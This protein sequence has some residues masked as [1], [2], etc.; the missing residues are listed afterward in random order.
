[1]KIKL[2]PLL[3]LL[4]AP[5]IT[6]SQDGLPVYT[7][8]LAD[9][10]YVIHPS[11]AGAA[12]GTR[13]RLGARQQWFDQKNAP[14]LQTLNVASRITER[15]GIG[16]IVFNDQNG[17]HS[18]TGGYLTYAHHIPFSFIDSELNQLS[19]GLS[20]GIIDSRLD[21]TQFNLENYDPIIY[22]NILSATYF[23][24]DAGVSYHFLDFAAHFTVKNLLYQ[25][26]LN[27]TE[28]IESINQRKYLLGASYA[29]GTMNKDWGFE[30]SFMFM[31]TE[32]TQETSVDLNFRAIKRFDGGRGWAGLSYRRALDTPDFEEGLGSK[33]D[34]M[35]HITPVIGI[36]FHNFVFAY[37]YSYQMGNVTFDNGGFHHLTLGYNFG[38]RQDKYDCNCPNVN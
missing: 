27:Y 11:M 25:K 3:L 17:F 21:E 36:N 19:F 24:M 32:G 15:S 20:A 34:A 26:R 1:M 28:E 35:Q 23:N 29:M 9:N 37:M 30:P 2:I 38:V 31:H 33:G 18:Q 6:F 14:N 22:G 12:P 5:L 8:Y 4:I 7:D 13:I 10:L 16:G